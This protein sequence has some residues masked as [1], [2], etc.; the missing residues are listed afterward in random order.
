[1]LFYT[2]VLL[3]R[4]REI[5]LTINNG[6]SAIET[7]GFPPWIR[8]LLLFLGRKEKIDLLMNPKRG[9]KRAPNI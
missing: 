6:N 1:M 4:K 5:Y 8:T 7:T 3:Y 2:L 9:F